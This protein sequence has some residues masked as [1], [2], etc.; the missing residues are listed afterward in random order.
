MNQLTWKK[1]LIE[2]YQTFRAGDFPKQRDLYAELG[3]NGQKPKVMIIACSDSRAD[4]SD[5]F[6]T[7]P[8][9]IFVVRNVA[10]IVQPASGKSSHY[11]TGA[12]IEYAVRHIGVEA[13]VV[14]G[15]EDCGGIRA[16][17]DGYCEDHPE[18]YISGWINVLEQA[19]T[20][21]NDKSKSKS[22]EQ[23]DLELAGVMA[24]VENLMSFPFVQEAVKNGKLAVMGAYFSIL[25]GKLMFADDSGN[26]S[27][28]PA[29]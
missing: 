1:D 15:H 26:F 28:V 13:I 20:R 22:V 19:E 3:A 25:Q 16:Y 8:G 29:K 18:S 5:I 21:L 6:H 7:Y 11:S 9:E 17:R 23:F 12:A 2:G 24:S 27:E 14:M 4:P 10:N